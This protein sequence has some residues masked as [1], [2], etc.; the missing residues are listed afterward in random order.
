MR[1]EFGKEVR[2]EPTAIT[3]THTCDS[4]PPCLNSA[5]EGLLCLAVAETSVSNRLV[6]WSG[7]IWLHVSTGWRAGP[8]GRQ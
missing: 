1:L 2:S 4:Y 7:G 5:C 6:T 8:G 3:P